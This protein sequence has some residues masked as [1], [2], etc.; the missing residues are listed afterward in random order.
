[1]ADAV[2]G[3][4]MP[5]FDKNSTIFGVKRNGTARFAPNSSVASSISNLKYEIFMRPES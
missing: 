4:V 5:M 3:P 1:M 2:N